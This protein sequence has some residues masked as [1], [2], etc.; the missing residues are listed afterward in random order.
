MS[1]PLPSPFVRYQ[2]SI[3]RYQERRGCTDVQY[4]QTGEGDTAMPRFPISPASRPH[5]RR[6]AAHNL[7]SRTC[8]AADP[9]CTFYTVGYTA[10]EAVVLPT[11]TF[12]FSLRARRRCIL[13]TT[14][15]SL[16]FR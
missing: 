3:V 5:A 11:V 14:G 10:E 1:H 16:R 8:T 12:T 13:K 4:S 15:R 9:S 6:K 7:V 2:L